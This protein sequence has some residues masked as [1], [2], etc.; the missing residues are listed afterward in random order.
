MSMILI[1]AVAAFIV[2]LLLLLKFKKSDPE[3]D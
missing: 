1:C 2:T 3:E